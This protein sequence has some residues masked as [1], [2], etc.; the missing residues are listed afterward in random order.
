MI[1]YEEDQDKNLFYLFTVPC[2]V[3]LDLVI[4]AFCTFL[5]NDRIWEV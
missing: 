3:L 2:S 5:S 4:V 1:C